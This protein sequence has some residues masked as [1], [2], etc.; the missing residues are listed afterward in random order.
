LD[1]FIARWKGVQQVSC[2]ADCCGGLR[3]PQQTQ[4]N[5]LYM[6]QI[7]QFNIIERSA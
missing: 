5:N 2:W 7:W 4:L 1:I 3:P 6:L